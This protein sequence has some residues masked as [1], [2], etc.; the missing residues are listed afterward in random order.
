MVTRRILTLESY[1][2]QLEVVC[3]YSDVSA[4]SEVLAVAL[5]GKRHTQ[6]MYGGFYALKAFPYVFSDHGCF[7]LSGLNFLFELLLSHSL[8][9]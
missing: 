4:L 9:T 7:L 3:Q 2:D 6:G 8:L 5:E 1:R